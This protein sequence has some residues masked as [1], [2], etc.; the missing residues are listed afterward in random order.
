MGSLTES[1]P[2]TDTASSGLNGR[3]QRIAQRITSLI[4]LLPS[5][6]GQKTKAGSLS[7]ALASDQD[8][9]TVGGISKVIDATLTRPND[10]TPYAADDE[11]SSS[12]SAP[13]IL[14]L[15]N[16]AR[17][18]GGS[19]YIHGATLITSGVTATNLELHIYDTTST[20]NN[21]NAAFSPSDT[22]SGTIAAVIPFNSYFSTPNNRIFVSSPILAPFVTSGSANLYARLV[23]RSAFTPIAQETFKVRLRVS[24]D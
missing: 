24:Q 16:C 20:P 4:A 8:A 12:T 18:S 22:E 3:L 11:I 2:G 15:S 5:S 21:D 1:A 7:V 10:T 9:L 23:T 13:T 14:T 6:I 17:V 19:G